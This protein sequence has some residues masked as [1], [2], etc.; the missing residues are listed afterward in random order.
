[1]PGPSTE[2]H[3][4]G[5]EWVLVRKAGS[6]H[7]GVWMMSAIF[8]NTPRTELQGPSELEAEVVTA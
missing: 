8:A 3:Q 7:I 4:Y 5:R 2:A 1:M 6:A